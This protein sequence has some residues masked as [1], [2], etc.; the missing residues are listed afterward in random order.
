VG[1]FSAILAAGVVALAAPAPAWA[2]HWPV[3]PFDREHP[4][5]GAFDD[6]REHEGLGVSYHSFHF[7]I[8][9]S[10]P[11][12]TAVYAVEA[13]TIYRYRDAVA[14]R[15]STGR[16]FAYWHVQ[17]RLPEHSYVV[18][19]QEI[20]RIRPGWGHVHFAERVDG[21]YVNPLRPGALEPFTDTTT[22]VVDAIDL[23]ADGSPVDLAHVTGRIDLIADAYDRP[24]IAPPPPWQDARWTPALV[25]WRLLRDDRE[26]VPWETAADFRTALLQPD[27]YEL[28]YAPGT[29]QDHPGR[30]GDFRFWL[31]HGF[32]TTLLDDGTYRLEV[33][34]SDT[35]GNTGRGFVDFTVAN[36]RAGKR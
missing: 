32:D 6:P 1:R 22:P 17:T 14:V 2:Y 9:I 30:P 36:R 33:T 12:G 4:I 5:R 19:N 27:Q 21:T 35:R 20:G 23:S 26:V 10:A 16:E 29:R 13:G 24:P 3:K 11:D 15:E 28:I 25:R 7:G 8:D 34:A 31:S 18:K